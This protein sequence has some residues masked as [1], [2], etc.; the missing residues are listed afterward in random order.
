MGGGEVAIV[1]GAGPQGQ[2]GLHGDAAV[3]FRRSASRA[4]GWAVS[5]VT[6]AMHAAVSRARRRGLVHKVCTPR[7]RSHWPVRVTCWRPIAVSPGSP[8][9]LR[10][11]LCCTR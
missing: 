8:G 7:P 5:P 3:Q 1:P 4:S 11:S 9:K 6:E 10:F 2:E